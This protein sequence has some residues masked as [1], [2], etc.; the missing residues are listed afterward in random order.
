[1]R[2]LKRAL[3]LLLSSTMVLGMLVMGSSA[4]GYQDVDASNV[5][6]EAIEVLQTV[7][8]MTGDQNGNFNPDGSITRNEMAV[9]MAHL[10]NLDYDYYRGTNPFT[11]VPEWAAPYVAACAAEGVVAGIGN[12]QFGGNNKVT[13]AQASLMIMKALGYF[14]NAE[15][16]GTDWQVATIRQASYIDL[17]DNI[18]ANAESALTRGQVA[19]LVLNGL[20][21]DMV[22]FTGD[23]GIQIGDVTV[24]YR[25]EYTPKTSSAAKYNSLVG[26][27]TDIAQQGQYYIQLGE[28]LYNGKLTM[29]ADTD[30]FQRP[31]TTW[32]YNSNTI[33]TYVNFDLMVGEYT[34]S[35]SGKE[36][37]DIV[38]KTA[39]DKYDFYSYVNGEK[40]N[41]YK[42][43]AKDNKANIY[44]NNSET[45]DNG[46][47]TQV[48]VNND[49]EE[50]IVTVINTYLAQAN[51]DYN[52][53]KDTASFE[54]YG[55]TG[56]NGTVSGEDFDIADIKAD[57]FVL[58]T[59]ADKEI[60]S[61]SDVEVLSKVEISKFSTSGGK[62]T[63]V[64]VDGTKYDASET[65]TYDTDVLKQYT[66]GS[67]TNL[68][69]TTYNVYLDQYGYAIGVDIV[70]GA[71]NYVFIT[72]MD[73]SSSNLA[74]KTW[75]ANAIFMDGT[76]AVIKVKNTDA[77]S[78]KNEEVV[79]EWFTYTKGN[80]DVYTLYAVNGTTAI[81]NGEENGDVAQKWTNA[82]GENKYIDSKHITLMG[83]SS[84]T[85]VYGDDDTVYLLADLDKVSNGGTDYAVIKGVDEVVTGI[86]NAAFELYNWSEAR[87]A[88]K[89]EKGSADKTTTSS[90]AYALYG[91]DGY[92]IAAVVVGESATVSKNAAYVISSGVSSES[93]NKTDKTWTWTRDVIIN[94]EEVELTETNDTGVSALKSDVMDQ[95]T[96]VVV[97]YDAN[98][99]VKDVE[100]L[101]DDYVTSMANAVTAI[102]DGEDLVYVQIA[103]EE[104]HEY[105][106]KSNTLYD[107]TTGKLG[108]RVSSD[109]K[110]ALKQMVNNK[111]TTTYD[112]GSA[113]L[114]AILEDLN[115]DGKEY[116]FNAVI[117]KGKATSVIIIDKTA[118]G[119]FTGPDGSDKT[120]IAKLSSKNNS[121]TLGAKIELTKAATKDTTYNV[122]LY[123]MNGGT[124]AKVDTVAVKVESGNNYGF[125]AIEGLAAGQQYKLVCGDASTLFTV[126]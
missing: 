63:A 83:V 30:A 45:I 121:G 44:N 72:G 29:R 1:M 4:A 46:T 8:I 122:E 50:V 65:L 91:D 16:F 89:A 40:D 42:Q 58:V 106:L 27:K 95:Y 109:V 115:E 120:D 99:N 43:I 55:L 101:T 54:V 64:T 126:D 39:F 77:V 5:N 88:V 80:D 35:V 14:Q 20:L 96:W 79:N 22:D 98:G 2:N 53:K 21:S 73:S 33:G 123:M 26:G 93:Y 117:E 116:E 28:E 107:E 9:V 86:D 108:F 23:K 124:W 113:T 36:L 7:G 19:Q 61:I 37:Y 81:L 6:Q 41:L 87:A 112:Q 110:I 102:E 104:D 17:F 12:G 59:Y 34:T 68:K 125:T 57:Q 82:T 3:S 118:D 100:P 52:A 90:G 51:A 74:T 56:E 47:L 85:R 92:V 111:T 60:Q 76:S 71:K 24:G 94:G 11:D 114:K 62:A 38:G 13:A 78:G 25:A 10:L 70:E 31:A 69:D 49:S 18:N 97:K 32:T 66:D 15:D 75:D 84:D 105:T 119:D 48:F 103:N 67:V